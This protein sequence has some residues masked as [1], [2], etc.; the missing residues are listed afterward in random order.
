MMTIRRGLLIVAM[1][2]AVAVAAPRE[3]GV[4][5]SII[6]NKDGR[7]GNEVGDL[8]AFYL[9]QPDK[10]VVLGNTA[11]TQ[12]GAMDFHAGQLW[13]A[14][15]RDDKLTFYTIN[16]AKAEATTKSTA[17]RKLSGVF[18]GD[19][20]SQGRF[21]I[22]NLREQYLCA[23]D[24]TTGAE[25]AAVKLPSDA[26]YNGVAFVGDVLYA[27]RGGTGDPPQEFG[28]LNTATG[29]FTA[30]GYT[31]VGYDGKGGGNG[32]GALDYNPATRTMYLVYR[33]GVDRA[34]V[35]PQSPPVAEST[36]DGVRPDGSGGK[37]SE[38]TDLREIAP[39]NVRRSRPQL[40]SLYTI[41]I[42]TGQSAFIG[43]ILPQAT[44]DAF[45]VEQ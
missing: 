1:L 32:C 28:T 4:G 15:A 25:V 7:G 29:E 42:R 39:G 10:G 33:Q 45:A 38:E 41:D 11:L 43:E 5:Y 31:N 2:M 13:A 12:V 40:W 8:V 27:V 30:I 22:V 35:L 17:Q 23:Y 21:W 19:F 14:S 26:A 3:A 37:G 20:D 44:Y 18:A 34:P 6:R 16:L 9:D 36:T 24:P